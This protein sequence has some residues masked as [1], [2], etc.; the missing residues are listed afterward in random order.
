MGPRATRIDRT[1]TPQPVAIPAFLYGASVM[2]YRYISSKPFY[3]QSDLLIGTEFRSDWLTITRDGN[4]I[5]PEHYAW[6][7]CTPAYY[8]GVWLGTPDLWKGKDGERIAY[9][10]SQ[11]HDALCQYAKILPISKWAASQ[12]F[13][14]MLI[15]RGAPK[16]LARLYYWGVM[17]FGP[18]AWGGYGSENN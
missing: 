8:V 17:A 5:I 4:L 9:R 15:E 3:Y 12:I 10:P 1:L 7:G 18:Q 11:V 14:D 2:V 16:W 13:A 6:D